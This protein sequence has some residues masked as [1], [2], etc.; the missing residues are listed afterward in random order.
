[1]K[2][3]IDARGIEKNITGVGRY[4]INLLNHWQHDTET[5]FLLYMKERIPDIPVLLSPNMKCMVLPLKKQSNALW[6]HYALPKQLRKDRPDIFFSPSYVLPLVA[7]CKTA[8]TLHDIYYEAHPEWVPPIDRVLLRKMSKLSAKKANIIFTVSEFSKREILRLYRVPEKKVIVTLL[9][10][11]ERFQ[12]FRAN[13]HKKEIEHFRSSY[14]IPGPFI[15]F[16]GSLFSRR[17]P[18]EMISAFLR[19][20]KETGEPFQFLMTGR[21]LTYP[22][23]RLN[24]HIAAVN[25]KLDTNALVHVPY[26]PDEDLVT[27]YN[28]A[29]CGLLY[30][31]DYEGFGIPALEA[32]VCGTPSVCTDSEVG[33]EILG[34]CAA[35][36]KNNNSTVEIENAIY[37]L[38]KNTDLRHTILAGAK[39]R[40]ALFD[41]K[42]CADRTLKELKRIANV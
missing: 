19:F 30:I 4:L 22:P 28:L 24:D 11:D 6:Q 27:A 25:A 5:T 32:L 9:G 39:K 10:V 34:P 31:S 41:Y 40:L 21:D 7:P 33:R 17:H 12:K 3:A 37:S 23:E 35:Y 13:T 38:V 36:V 1:M 15:L 14:N 42:Q 2:I 20:R 29:S 26:L 8:V 16:N 18:R